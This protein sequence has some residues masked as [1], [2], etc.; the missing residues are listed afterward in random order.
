[1]AARS[2]SYSYICQRVDYSDDPNEVRVSQDIV[3]NIVFNNADNILIIHKNGILTNQ[4]LDIEVCLR[5]C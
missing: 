1:M 5:R 2:A 3:F 4:H